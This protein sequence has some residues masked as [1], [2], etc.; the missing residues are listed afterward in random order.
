MTC[1]VVSRGSEVTTHVHGGNSWAR[2]GALGTREGGS[3]GKTTDGFYWSWG[4]CTGGL[5]RRVGGQE[6]DGKGGLTR[7][8]KDGHQ[9]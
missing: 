4:R 6:T 9:R 8:G 3:A 2:M 7:R 1:N 5:V